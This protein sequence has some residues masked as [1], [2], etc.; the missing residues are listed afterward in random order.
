MIFQKLDGLST[1]M[2]KFT[3]ETN[4]AMSIHTKDTY[5]DNLAILLNSIL[6]DPNYRPLIEH[7]ELYMFGKMVR[8]NQK[9]IRDHP[10][11]DDH[12]N[13]VVKPNLEIVLQAYM[14]GMV[15]DPNIIKAQSMKDATRD[16]LFK[17][18]YTTHCRGW[19]TV[20][21]SKHHFLFNMEVLFD[22]FP[23]HFLSVKI[24]EH[25]SEI[26]R[27]AWTN[28]QE[29]LFKP[30]KADTDPV[31]K[32]TPPQ[33][34]LV[35][36]I[37]HGVTLPMNYIVSILTEAMCYYVHGSKLIKGPKEIL[38][39][40]KDLYETDSYQ[41]IVNLSKIVPPSSYWHHIKRVEKAFFPGIDDEKSGFYHLQKFFGD[42]TSVRPHQ[43][44]FKE[45]FP[46]DI[47][48]YMAT[49]IEKDVSNAR[50][51]GHIRCMFAIR[52]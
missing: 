17:T 9:T 33:V 44:S 7:F 20:P 29:D 11:P 23:F 21:S 35:H 12:Y 24:I 52:K 6:K 37:F 40:Y 3:M 8:K 45:L 1:E 34:S 13:L 32:P 47:K 4:K 2:K 27:L 51:K 19:L 38:D 42:A 36:F 18:L 30:K 49:K 14:D 41:I 48:S 39:F 46:A 43:N 10:N 50:N 28:T 16:A 25:F 22:P 26:Y 5:I 15:V 31:T